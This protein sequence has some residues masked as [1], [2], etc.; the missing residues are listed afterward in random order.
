MTSTDASCSQ[1]SVDT[2]EPLAGSAP[3][4]TAWMVIEHPGP[5]GRDAL[6][7][8]GLNSDW[9]EHLRTALSTHGVR[10]I[11][12]RRSGARRGDTRAE[13][14]EAQHPYVPPP[15]HNVWVAAC[16]PSGGVGRHGQISDFSEL[17][18]WDIEALGHGLLPEFGVAME[19]SWEFVCTHG[20]RDVCCA[21]SGRQYALARQAAAPGAHVWECSHL[22]GH[23]FAPTC[24]FLPSGRLYGRLDAAGFYP[25]GTEPPADFLRGASYLS[26]AAQAADQAVRSASAMPASA[27]T[28][29]RVSPDG[30][31]EVSTT[32]NV[33]TSDQGTWHVTCTASTIEAPASCGAPSTVR[34]V[35]QAEIAGAP[36]EAH[37]DN[38]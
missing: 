1:H 13:P 29:L 8:S 19:D 31:P 38:P 12:A 25:A 5:W 37:P 36:A 35:W 2:H 28:H 33:E 27:P 10:T 7:D 26:P 24:L 21:T 32:V 11:L 17:L 3:S 30:L 23:R 16:G 18:Q 14:N 4:A 15:S 9:V 34:T 6:E 20:K 22:G